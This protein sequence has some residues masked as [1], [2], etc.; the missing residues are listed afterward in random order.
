MKAISLHEKRDI[1]QYLKRNVYLNLYSIGDLDDFFWPFTTWYGLVNDSQLVE[2]ALVYSGHTLPTL[3]ALSKNPGQLQ[4]LLEEIKD[5]L[6]PTFYAHLSPTVHKIFQDTHSLTHHGE[7]YKMALMGE[8]PFPKGN[9]GEVVHIPPSEINAVKDLYQKSYPENWF[10][11][12]MLETG[13]YFGIKDEA[14][15]EYISIAGVHVYSPTYDVAAIGNIATHPQ[16][17]GKGYATQ[18]TAYL[19]ES[20]SQKVK[21]IGLN[22]KVNN[23]A[24]IACYKKLGFKRIGKYHEFTVQNR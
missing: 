22:V 10:D 11:P 24:A 8:P 1:Y 15:D 19:C 18:V 23:E 2:V 5:L 12:R 7:H 3:L 21:F 13:Q 17:R 9:G 16:Y 20:L 4:T 14:V 6:P